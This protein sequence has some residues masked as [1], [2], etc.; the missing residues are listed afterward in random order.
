VTVAAGESLPRGRHVAASMLSWLQFPRFLAV[1]A[2]DLFVTASA[3]CVYCLQDDE[4]KLD[5]GSHSARTPIPALEFC[6]RC[7]RCS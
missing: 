4:R 5:G 6:R 1:V 3:L 2:V 7:C